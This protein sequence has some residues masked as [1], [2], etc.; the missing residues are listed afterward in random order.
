[1]KCNTK[2]IPIFLIV[3]LPLLFLS[4]IKKDST[5][6]EKLDPRLQITRK[7]LVIAQPTSPKKSKKE[8]EKKEAKV[9][10]KISTHGE[11]PVVSKGEKL[12]KKK[13]VLCHGKRG[14]GKK[15]QKAPRIGGQHDW[16][17]KSEIRDI[18]SKKR[19][20]KSVKKMMP[21]VKSLSEDEINYLAT[22]ISSL[23]WNSKK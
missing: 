16:Y 22:Y 7:K 19:N 18:K 5:L 23:P 4:C 13:C 17:I 15:S 9:A 14:E 20:Y 21:Y 10:A 2:N 1:M 6:D 8:S 11:A 3:L 12:F